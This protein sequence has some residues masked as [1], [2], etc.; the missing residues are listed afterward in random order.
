[1]C[2]GFVE[3][4]NHVPCCYDI[5]HKRKIPHCATTINCS[6]DFRKKKTL[7]CKHSVASRV[8][9]LPRKWA[10]PWASWGS[11]KLPTPTHMAAA[12]CTHNQ[13]Q[14][15]SCTIVHTIRWSTSYSE[16]C[17]HCCNKSFLIS[18]QNCNAIQWVQCQLFIWGCKLYL[19]Y[20]NKSLQIDYDKSWKLENFKIGV[21]SILS[22]KKSVSTSIT[23]GKQP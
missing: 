20:C 6:V 7:R 5:K 18:V 23:H 8:I 10:K 17:V 14:L 12:A 21:F 1:M 15:W 11:E 4:L 19:P 9:H 22:F 13:F 16:Q 2:S 3:V